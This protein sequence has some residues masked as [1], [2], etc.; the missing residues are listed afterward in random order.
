MG[1]WIWLVVAV[2]YISH[3]VFMANF[4]EDMP[5]HGSFLSFL[6][7][8]HERQLD[9]AC[10]NER[11]L[12]AES[13]LT[14]L[15]VIVPS[16]GK[17]GTTSLHQAF[18]SMGMR[19]FHAEEKAVY[20]Q[21]TF[22]DGATA[23]ELART[24]SRCRLDAIFLEPT[25]DIFPDILARSPGAKVIMNWREYNNWRASVLDSMP[26]ERAKFAKA[27]GMLAVASLFAFPWELVYD[28]LSGGQVTRMF[29]EAPTFICKGHGTILQFVFGSLHFNYWRT[30]NNVYDRGIFKT[31][32]WEEAVLAF[33]NEVRKLTPPDL[34]LDFDQKRHGFA[35][36][37]EF[38]GV[39]APKG[40][41]YPH[42]RKAYANSGDNAMLIGHPFEY[43]TAM[44]IAASL[45]LVNIVI[46]RGLMHVAG[47]CARRGARLARGPGK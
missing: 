8:A 4:W 14:G 24:I 7:R 6:M 12:A 21:T 42:Q 15:K 39:P 32:I 22:R 37:E 38:L 10:G 16:L 1:R 27:M 23:D 20:A 29:Q 9:H 5:R 41:P 44:C 34:Y 26:Q 18:C 28:L 43:C 47:G 36:L 31:L 19:S 33:R 25:T 11:G 17:M 46:W 3:L 40:E 30:G 45:H 2:L 13:N 35:E